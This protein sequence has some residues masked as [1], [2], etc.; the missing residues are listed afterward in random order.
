[1]SIALLFPEQSGRDPAA[2]RL[3]GDGL[4]ASVGVGVA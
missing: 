2:H 3:A 1:M 4:R